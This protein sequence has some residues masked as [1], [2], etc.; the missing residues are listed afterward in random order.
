MR[1]LADENISR[2]VV[3]ALIEA[4][5]DTVAIA[6]V[7]PAAPD[8]NVL[9]MAVREERVL[10]TFDS[11]FG[12]MIFAEGFAAPRAVIYLRSPPPS[13]AE[14]ITRILRVA[15]AD[16][17]TIDGYFVSIDRTARYHPLPQDKTNA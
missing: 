11:D 6:D 16:A 9:D 15:S 14:A 13:P 4:G 5:H 2:G 7:S 3:Q 12:R 8:D 10:L 17:P 1:I